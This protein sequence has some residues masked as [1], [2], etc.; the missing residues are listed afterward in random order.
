MGMSHPFDMTHEQMTPEEVAEYL[1]VPVS[2]VYAW[3]YRGIGPR[4][5]KI[6]RHVR[7]RRSDVDAWYEDQAD[8]RPAA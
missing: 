1:R 8:P 6:G 3:R 7:Y 4:G 2:T 5:H